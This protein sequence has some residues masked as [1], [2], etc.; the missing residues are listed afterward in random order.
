MGGAQVDAQTHVLAV[1]EIAR[2]HVLEIVEL[3]VDQDAVEGAVK[4]ALQTAKKDAQVDV[5][6]R[7]HIH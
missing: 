1:G 3:V 5:A 2:A 4:I 6:E 7:V